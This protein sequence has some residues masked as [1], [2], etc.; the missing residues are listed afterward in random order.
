MLREVAKHKTVKETCICE[1]DVTVFLFS[2]CLY[3]PILS[4]NSFYFQ[5][6]TQQVIEVSKRY[7]TQ[8]AIDFS[9][10]KV[11][12]H[13]QDGAEFMQQCTGQFDV[14]ITDSSDPIG[15]E[16]GALAL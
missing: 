9:S 6:H 2:V 14:T 4:L 15:E 8:T 10:P 3:L 1:I 7:L 5:T 11:E 12:V 13:I 16:S